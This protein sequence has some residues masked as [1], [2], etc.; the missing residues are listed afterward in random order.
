VDE[1]VV[2]DFDPSGKGIDGATLQR[3]FRSPAP[4]VL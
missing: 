4:E 3:I 2:L 1:G